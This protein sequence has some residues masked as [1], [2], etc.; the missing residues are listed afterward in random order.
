MQAASS[1]LQRHFFFFYFA[2][3]CWLLNLMSITIPSDCSTLFLQFSRIIRKLVECVCVW[4]IIQSHGLNLNK[5]PN[6][7]SS[8][9]LHMEKRGM[10][11]SAKAGW[12]IMYKIMSRDLNLKQ[13]VRVRH[14]DFLRRCVLMV[15]SVWSKLFI[16]REA[17]RCL[18]L[19]DPRIQ[20]L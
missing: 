10:T 11:W 15:V 18:W 2:K 12:V 8:A 9:N 7:V 3:K 19:V 20:E 6:T 17:F 16:L 13:S 4:F 14:E 1:F 5:T